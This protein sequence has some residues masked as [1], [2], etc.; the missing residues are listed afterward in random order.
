VGK[1][2]ADAVTRT[3]AEIERAAMVWSQC[4]VTLGDPDTVD[5][6]V[7]DPPPPHLL[8]LGCDAGAPAT[9]GL[10]RFDVDG[11][12]IEAKLPAGTMPRG[13]ARIAAAAIR[14]AGFDATE[15][16]GRPGLATTYAP[17]DVSVR[18]KNGTLATISSPGHAAS[19]G[20]K[21]RPGHASTD[22]TLDACIGS[23]W[24][25]DG[26]D[27][28]TD[29]TASQGSIE[30]RTLIRAFDDGDPRT[31]EVFVVPSFGGMSRIGESF[32]FADRSSIRN[33]VIE[34]RVG[35]RSDRASFTL[36]HEL[37]H[38][39]MD[40]PGHPDDFDAD[41]PTR[42]MDSDAVDG[43]VFG[44]RRI[45]LDE[46]ARALRESGPSSRVQLLTP[47]ASSAAKKRPR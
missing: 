34:D 22:A 26:L 21:V 40:D 6:E 17:S 15:F 13:A 23:V 12:S 45:S 35:F 38:V 32:I 27:H 1:D 20:V 2:D 9:G 29:A 3:R 11:K 33:V 28:F 47:V 25:G 10:L 16:D 44:P 42:L 8:A 7:V 41:T 46:C 31:I 14:R 30:E 18:R 5:V 4:G 24:L 43:T 39:L 36:A 37:G 19:D